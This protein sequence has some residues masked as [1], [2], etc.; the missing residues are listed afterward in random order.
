M[1][2]EKRGR[3][4][5]FYRSV[6]TGR[7]TRKVYCGGGAVGQMAAA[8]DARRREQRQADLVARQA[9]AAHLQE[10]EGLARE[11]RARCQLLADAVLLVSGFHR[12]YRLA[13]RTWHAARRA[14][15]HELARAGRHR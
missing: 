4:T 1:A 10:V 12:P 3:R 5:Y 6:R 11:L 8:A 2:W 13:W 14:S 15:K 7:R 9:K